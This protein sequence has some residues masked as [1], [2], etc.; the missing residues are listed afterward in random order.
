MSLNYDA[1]KQKIKN[2]TKKYEKLKKA[3][4]TIYIEEK[5]ASQSRRENFDK[6]KGIKEIDNKN[7]KKIYDA[8]IKGMKDCE[9]DREKHLEKLNNLI[10]PVTEYYPEEI[11]KSQQALDEYVKQKQNTDDL[12]KSTRSNQEDITRSRNEESRKK[13]KYQSNYSK[14]K[15]NM[16][17]DNKCLFLHFIHS[18]LKYHCAAL[19]RMSNLFFE[20]NKINPDA[21]ID[22][23]AKSLGI[24]NFD[25]KKLNIDIK[26]LKKE[27]KD[28]EDKEEEEK[29]DVLDDSDSEGKKDDEEDEDDDENG[30]GTD[31]KKSTKKSKN[32]TKKS[33]KSSVLKSSKKEEEEDEDDD[34]K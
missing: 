27:N 3:F 22:D 29:K 33:K 19:E 30:K 31:V 18:E 9:D 1:E 2:E 13:S 5:K 6:M 15:K 32:S 34:E 26:K 23:L 16:K 21:K 10:I 7:L 25:Y 14:Y 17:N 12:T 4:N 28:E 20:I 11:K 24:K 8:F